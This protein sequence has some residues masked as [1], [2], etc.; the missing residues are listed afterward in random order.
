MRTGLHAEQKRRTVGVPL[1]P[2]VLKPER[3]HSRPAHAT[4][5][6]HGEPA[7]EKESAPTRQTGVGENRTTAGIVAGDAGS[8][9]FAIAREIATALARG[10]RMGPG[11][12]TALQVMPMVGDG[13]VQA[14]TDVLTLPDAD[15]AIVPVS[16]VDRFRDATRSVDV[17]NKLIYIAPLFPEELHVLARAEISGIRDLD[18]KVVNVG[19]DGSAAAILGREICAD[20][21]VHIRE[22]H[23]S[24]GDRRNAERRDLG[25][26]P[27]FWEAGENARNLEAGRGFPFPRNSIFAKFDARFSSIGLHAQGLSLSRTLKRESRYHR[28]SLSADIL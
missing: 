16:L 18:G 19:E 28:R 2:D 11:G 6:A 9:E 12:E 3:W 10:R 23:A 24:C 20:L 4:V 25:F 22:A 17:R 1:L 5:A 13:G 7:V 21:G 15:M 8:T 27:G 26:I 14:I